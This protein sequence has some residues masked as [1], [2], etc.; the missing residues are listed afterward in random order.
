M[1]TTNEKMR[2]GKP[3]RITGNEVRVTLFVKHVQKLFPKITIVEMVKFI[4]RYQRVKVHRDWVTRTM[5]DIDYE[6]FLEEEGLLEEGKKELVDK[7]KE[8]ALMITDESVQDVKL[9]ISNSKEQAKRIKGVMMD[10]IDDRLENDAD[11]FTNDELIRGSVSMDKIE[12]DTE[13][14]RPININFNIDEFNNVYGQL[15]NKQQQ[16]NTSG[17]EDSPDDGEIQEG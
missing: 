16:T 8:D 10:E 3:E 2:K 12:K 14:N 13:E 11:T 7:T 6:K 9:M 17:G 5:K 15:K 4:L 1:S